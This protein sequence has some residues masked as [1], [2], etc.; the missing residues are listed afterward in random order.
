MTVRR[1]PIESRED[2]RLRVLLADDDPVSSRILDR[3]VRKWG[4]DPIPAANGTEAWELLQDPRTRLA[5]L[6][7]E[8]PAPTVRSS[9]AASGPRARPTIPTSS[10]SRPATIRATSLP[11]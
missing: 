8:M 3:Y 5:I 11:D 7:W 10:C 4:F 2:R 6:D 9:A 1:P